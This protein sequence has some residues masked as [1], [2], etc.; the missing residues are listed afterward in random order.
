MRARRRPKLTEANI[1]VKRTEVQLTTGEWTTIF[2]AAAVSEPSE[3]YLHQGYT[4]ASGPGSRL[5][6]LPQCG[7]S[8]ALYLQSQML[9][10]VSEV[11]RPHGHTRRT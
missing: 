11:R 3:A 1:P 4:V 10:L 2:V 9:T 5:M 7:F 6:I 8:V